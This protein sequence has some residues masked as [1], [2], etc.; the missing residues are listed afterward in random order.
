[1]FQCYTIFPSGNPYYGH[2]LDGETEAQSDYNVSPQ[3]MLQ[4]IVPR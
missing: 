3:A 2:F 4:K 1:M